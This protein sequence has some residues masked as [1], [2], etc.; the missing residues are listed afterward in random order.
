MHDDKMIETLRALVSDPILFSLDAVRAVGIHDD[1]DTELAAKLRVQPHVPPELRSKLIEAVRS[2]RHLELEVPAIVFRQQIGKPNKNGLRFSTKSLPKVAASYAGKPMLVDHRSWMQSSRIGTIAASE[3]VD[4]KL[5]TEPG[6]A[7]FRQIFRVVKPEAVISVLDGTIDRFS[8]GWDATGAVICTAHGTEV[9]TECDCWP[10]ETVKID[11]QS[12]IVEY[13]FTQAE[14]D[15]TSSVNSPAV[16]GTKIEDVRAALAA[17]LR[18]TPKARK[19]R[20]MAFPKLAAALALTALSDEGDETR[21]VVVVQTLTM[22]RDTLRTQLAEARTELATTKTALADAT[23]S[24]REAGISAVIED[25]Y[26]SGKLA[27][28]RDEKGKRIAGKV[29][30]QL[31]KHG[32]TLG[33]DALRD[34]VAEMPEIVPVGQ[35]ALAD[36]TEEPERMEFA[37]GDDA[38]LAKEFANVAAQLG[39]DPKTLAENHAKLSRGGRAI[40]NLPSVAVPP[41]VNPFNPSQK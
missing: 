12:V 30:T 39:V 10:L 40:V 38:T 26:R 22:E 3:L 9:F 36:E 29:E 19:H 21:A 20:P 23:K 32:E 33:V 31:R 25:A 2:G 1:D 11:K 5:D 27:I 18:K 14:G 8:I 37:A 13:E 17:Q 41:P 24:A 4:G 6:G 16:S 34:Y 28:K 35:R 15:E 7:A